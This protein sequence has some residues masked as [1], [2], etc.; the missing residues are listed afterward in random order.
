M[1]NRKYILTLIVPIIYL[2]FF[3]VI[4][5]SAPPLLIGNASLKLATLNSPPI[6][7]LGNAGLNAT[8]TS[9]DGSLANPYIIEN[10]IVNAS[11]SAYGIAISDTNAYFILRN[12]TV[13]NAVYQGIELINVTNGRIENT[14]VLHNSIGIYIEDSNVNTV[15]TV[16][17]NDNV[18]TGI[19][20]DTSNHTTLIN[21]TVSH[22]L[23][24]GIKLVSSYH[25]T[26]TN[27]SANSNF[28]GIDLLQSNFNTLNRTITNENEDGIYLSFSHNNSI[29][30]AY[31]A[32]NENI[33]IFLANSVNNTLIGVQVYRQSYTGIELG[34][35]RNNKVI[36]STVNH[37]G[38]GIYL[39]DSND[40]NTLT[41]NTLFNNSI[42][43]NLVNSNFNRITG[44]SLRGNR[45]CILQTGCTGNIFENNDCGAPD[46]TLIL[47]LALGIIAIAGSVSFATYLLRRR[48]HQGKD[49]PSKSSSLSSKSPKYR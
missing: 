21:I 45:Q 35:C 19:W 34:T 10:T 28:G 30:G 9:G 40:S 32:H 47:L 44:N 33:G 6:S 37:N 15:T 48:S 22:N 23:K 7:I 31:A 20:L 5:A 17:A 13:T 29:T 4:E 41:G 16:I 49:K 24:G 1:R 14:T 42:A 11:G 38:M 25:N 18:D 36:N 26:L 46:N 39:G 8:A 2:T 27:V 3:G 12:C 43:I